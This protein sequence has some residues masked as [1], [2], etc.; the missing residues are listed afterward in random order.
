MTTSHSPVAIRRSASWKAMTPD[1]Q[2]AT[3]V[4]TG[5]VRPYFIE[6]WAAAMLPETAGMANGLTWPGPFSQSV[7]A[8]SMTC[9]MP[10]PPVLMTT[11]D[12]V[13]LLGRPGGEVEPRALDGLGR[14]GH[15]EVDEPAHPADHLAVHRERRVEVLDL[16][17]D[18]HVV[19]G[20]VEGR[21]RPG[22]GDAGEE[23]RPERRANRC[24]SG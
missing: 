3:W 7:L 12:P 8:P 1:A 21:D 11:A 14:G 19:A 18:L 13:P 17:R 15:P 5:P 22:P 2:A 20:R 4:M 23:V 24:R 6:T 16:G 10:P 9:S